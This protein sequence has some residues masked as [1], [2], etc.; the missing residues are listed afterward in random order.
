MDSKLA[1]AAQQFLVRVEL[2]GSE[3]PA[4]CAV[5]DALQKFIDNKRE[6]DSGS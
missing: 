3:V 6:E 4:F 1:S 2:N 5:M